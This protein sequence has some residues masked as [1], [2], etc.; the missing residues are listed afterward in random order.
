MNRI[1][2]EEIMNYLQKRYDYLLSEY[3]TNQIL[4]VFVQ[5]LANFGFARTTTDIEVVGCYIPSFEELCASSPQVWEVDDGEI[6]FQLADIRLILAMARQQKE[7]VV[8]AVFTEYSIINPSYTHIFTNLIYANR[9]A[10]F[11]CDKKLRVETSIQNAMAALEQYEMT[12]DSLHLFMAC[13]KRIAARLYLNGTSLEN[14][15]NLKK[16]YH[17]N[18]L[19]DILDGKIEPDLNEIIG[20]LEELK[21]E[22]A[23]CKVNRTD[24]RLITDCVIEI[25]RTSLNPIT[26]KEEF[27]T[28][29]TD[30]E[31]EALSIIHK[32]LPEKEGNI[33]ISKLLLETSVSRPVFK[34][35]LRKMEECNYAQIE[36]QGV[37][38]TYIKLYEEEA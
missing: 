11:R 22:C 31:K 8:Q 3:D 2:D 19:W 29:L 25:I 20:E 33:S 10:M 9:E 38:G 30:A 4:G 35:L 34:N 13:R 5:G 21:K 6:K 7:S 14:C 32:N 17:I 26:P 27:L 24:K 28:G 23:G 1:S 12:K 15:I 18:Y 37:K 16:D 36:N